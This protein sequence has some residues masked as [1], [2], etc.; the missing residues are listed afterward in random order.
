MRKIFLLLGALL[1]LVGTAGFVLPRP[2]LGTFAVNT[3]H[4][5]VH[6]ASGVLTLIASTQGI[7]PMRTWGRAFGFAY[8]G[9]GIVGFIVPDVFGLMHLNLADNLLHLA[10]A[11]PFLYVGLLAP[12][13]L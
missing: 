9:L 2:V 11:L 4:N 7:G 10:L 5:I 13:R 3:L 8:L 1:L 12:P 6:V